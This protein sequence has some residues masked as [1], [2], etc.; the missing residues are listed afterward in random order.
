MKRAGYIQT[1]GPVPY[2]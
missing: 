2:R 1:W